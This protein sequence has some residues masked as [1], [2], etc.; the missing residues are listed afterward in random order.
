MFLQSQS[1]TEFPPT[2]DALYRLEI[3]Q[4][5]LYNTVRFDSLHVIYLGVRRDITDNAF[6]VMELENYNKR[7]YLKVHLVKAANQIYK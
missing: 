5:R 6:H 3:F 4:N 7:R 1:A 2:L